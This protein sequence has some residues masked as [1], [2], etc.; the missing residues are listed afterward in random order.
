MRIVLLIF[1]LL[2]GI[3]GLK[4]QNV[5]GQP[6]AKVIDKNKLTI[7]ENCRDGV[8]DM[9]DNHKRRVHKLTNHT[10]RERKSSGDVKKKR[11]TRQLHRV[12][13]DRGLNKGGS[14]R[15]HRMIKR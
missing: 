1:M 2:A 10:Q 12:R 6:T 14:A 3:G 8:T 4:A 11:V 5:S 15:D 7:H 9:H 13:A